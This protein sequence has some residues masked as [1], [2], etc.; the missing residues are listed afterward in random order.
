MI[1]RSSLILAIGTALSCSGADANKTAIAQRPAKVST[2]LPDTTHAVT[3]ARAGHLPRIKTL[4]DS[5]PVRGLYLNR[6]VAQSAKRM[7]EQIAIADR[8]EINAFVVD[9]KDEFG[10]NFQSSDEMLRKNAGNTHG[11]VAN[12]P[13]LLDSLHAHQI[14]AI[15]RLVVFKDPVA[16]AVS[17]QHTIRKPDGT[18]WRD[19]KNTTW[20][21]PYDKEIWEYNI[22][23]AEE[24]LR[25]G[26]D[27]IQFDYIRFPEPYKSLP[28]QVFPGQTTASKPQ[29]LADFLTA[30]CDRIHKFD[31][32]CAADIFGLVT[33]VAGALEV[34]QQWEKLSLATD[35]LL[36]M[37]YPSHYPHGSFGIDR[38]NAEPYKVI[39]AAITRAHQR[40]T[41]LGVKTAEHVRPWLQAFSLGQPPYGPDQIKEQ[42]RAVYDAGYDG[43]ILWHPGSKYEP[44]LAGLDS[45][46]TSKKKR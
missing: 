5:T 35:V 21:N 34:G 39:D 14:I 7:R 4:G 23:V 30:A 10:L 18:P 38:P 37:V 17:P 19:K 20:V 44:F 1:R 25:A 24:M 43:W 41:K 6:F 2:A 46:L 29:L 9:M 11:H 13:A 3:A 42:K 31:A 8:T 15:A 27:E 16:A 22:R 12:V 36:P 26:F 28:T 40:D 32:R 33:S 45:V